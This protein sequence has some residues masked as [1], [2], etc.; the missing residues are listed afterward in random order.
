T[1]W[2]AGCGKPASPVRRE[3]GANPIASPYPYNVSRRLRRP[4]CSFSISTDNKLFSRTRRALTSNRVYAAT[5]WRGGVTVLPAQRNQHRSLRRWARKRDAT[6][7]VRA[8]I[9]T[10][11]LPLESIV[12]FVQARTDVNAR[13]HRMY[14][15]PRQERFRSSQWERLAL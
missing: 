15:S 7:T 3:G 1:N 9:D 12:D 6:S 14:S 5:R 2:R 10:L 4:D 11:K 13:L 8:A